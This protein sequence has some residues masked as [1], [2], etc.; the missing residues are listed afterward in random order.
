MRVFDTVYISP[1]G[2]KRRDRIEAPNLHELRAIIRKRG[3]G[4]VIKAREK[5]GQ[6][7]GNKKL[8]ERDLQLLMELLATFL[9]GDVPI[10][11]SLEQLKDTSAFRRNTR[12]VLRG[13]YAQMADSRGSLSQAC[14]KY[15][16][17]FP[18]ELVMALKI[19]EG[20]GSRAIAETLRSLWDDRKFQQEMKEEAVNNSIYP[21]F[22]LLA[23]ASLIVVIITVLMP[24]VQELIRVSNAAPPASMVTLLALSAFVQKY[25]VAAVAALVVLVVAFL[26]LQKRPKVRDFRDRMIVKS[27]FLGRIVKEYAVAG[28]TKKYRALYKAGELPAAN[29]E[30]CADATK[31]RAVSAA[32]LRAKGLLEQSVVRSEG[33]DAPP[34]TD[35]FRST[36]LFPVLALTILGT[37]EKTG[38]IENGLSRVSEIYANRVK[39][40]LMRAMKIYQWAVFLF[41]GSVVGYVTLSVWTTIYQATAAAE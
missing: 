20:G 24:K 30:A 39:K 3:G 19:G 13:V 33:G 16:K 41:A 15:P 28:I 26:G 35:A 12:A 18:K 36:G 34:V 4:R 8:P 32:L 10:L 9:E 27:P 5:R 37:A 7:V 6:S 23:T 31:N 14:S 1:A 22:L 25:G 21:A 38:R 11:E 29:L 17:A 2:T 40:D